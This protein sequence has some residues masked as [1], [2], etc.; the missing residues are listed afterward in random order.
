MTRAMKSVLVLACGNTLRG[1]DGVAWHIG[2]TLQQDGADP[3]AEIVLT[4]QLLPEHAELMRTADLVVFI[5][6]TAVA[7]PGVISTIPITPADVQ[8]PIFTH[9]LD[10]ASL[11]KLAQNLYGRIPS[12]AIAITVGGQSF[13]L[14]EQL[15]KPVTAAIPI[16]VEVVRRAYVNGEQE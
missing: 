4:H 12:R 13:E 11:L 10:P 14:N 1:D 15:S 2:A 3:D 8:F 6:C 16:A 9:H 5:D 7:G